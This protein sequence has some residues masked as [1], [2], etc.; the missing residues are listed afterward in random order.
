MPALDAYR[1]REPGYE[2]MGVPVLAAE[3]DLGAPLREGGGNLA[4][5]L[6]PLLLVLDPELGDHVGWAVVH[7]PPL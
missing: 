7:V 2:R 3:D 6:V 4:P 5:I 1:V